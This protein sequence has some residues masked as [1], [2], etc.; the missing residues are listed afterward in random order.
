MPERLLAEDRQLGGALSWSQPAKLADF[1]ANSPFAG[2]PVPAEVTVSRQVLAEP[3]AQLADHTWARLQDGTPLVTEATRGAGR[4]VLFHVTGN[5]DW[6]NL[7]LSG[8]FPEMLR[9]LVALSAGI[10]AA[11]DAAPLSPAETLNGFG[12]LGTPPPA[13]TGLAAANFAKTAVSPQHPPG[14]Y[15]PEAGRR[16]L[17][18]SSAMGKLELAAS[19]PN[20]ARQDLNGGVRERAIGPWL[21]AAGLALL[22]ID[23]LLALRLRGLLRPALAAVLLLLAVPAARAQ[24]PDPPLAR[25]AGDAPCIHRLG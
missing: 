23:L 15:G 24:L 12:V 9:R 4:V 22:A 16:A 8:L 17:N 5:A 3:S 1:P 13:A 2:L 20:A 7:P 10:S 11:P 6:S 14:L 21:V 19:V 18:L 25:R